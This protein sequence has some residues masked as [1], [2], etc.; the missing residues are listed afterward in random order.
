MVEL[1]LSS[2]GKHTVHVGAD[3]PEE[4]VKLLPQAQVIYDAVVRKYG[5]KARMWHE[6][7]NGETVKTVE[8]KPA[9]GVN[10]PVCPMHNRPMA[11]RKGRFG[12]FWSCPTRLP[13]GGW[14]TVTKEAAKPA[15]GEVAASH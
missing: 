3:T 6:A 12:D 15:N 2:D 10:A 9:N 11:Y 13:H 8:A 14:C 4:M 7:G 5:T 1:Y